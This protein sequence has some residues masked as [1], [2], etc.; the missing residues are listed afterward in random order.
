MN[1]IYSVFTCDVW[2]M[3]NSFR[4]RGIFTEEKKVRAFVKAFIK[5]EVIDYDVNSCGDLNDDW[6]GFTLQ[7]ITSIIPEIYIHEGYDGECEEDG[8]YLC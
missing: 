6:S 1:K 7:E 5:N 2:K 4:L 8:G 3:D